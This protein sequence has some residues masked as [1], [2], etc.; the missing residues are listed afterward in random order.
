VPAIIDSQSVKTTESGGIRGYD[1]GKKVVGRKR[2][3]PTDTLG[4][5][6]VITVH[7]A[8]IQDRDGFERVIDKVERRFPWLRIVFADSGY[9]ALQS[10]CAAAQNRLRL[11]IVKRPHHAEGFHLLPRPLRGLLTA[12][13]SGI[14]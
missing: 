11:E 4:L 13:P 9:N 10:E 14:G 5:P 3:L 1:A 2:H 7:S 12:F 6:L 8:G